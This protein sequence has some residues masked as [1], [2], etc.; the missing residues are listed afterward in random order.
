VEH[1]YASRLADGAFAGPERVDTGL[2]TPGS[3][4]A[5]A[6]SDGGRLVIAFVNNGTVYASVRPAGANAFPAPQPL[7]AGSSPAADMSFNGAAYVVWS[8]G[9]DVRAARL[10]RTATAFAGIAAPLDLDPAQPAGDTAARAPAVAI[11][12]DGTGIATWGEGS[13]VVARRLF[14]ANLS[15]A[16]QD[17]TITDLSGHAGGTADSPRVSMEDDS[18]F[19]WVVF[20]QALDGVNRVVARR[21]VGS[22]F[23]PPQVVDGMGF[24][25]DE[26]LDPPAFAMSGRGVGLAITARTTSNSVW[27]AP[28]QDDTFGMGAARVDNVGNTVDPRPI[29]TFAENND[30]FVA[31]LQSTGPTDPVAIQGRLFDNKQGLLPSGFVSK[32]DLGPVD[33]S[34]GFDAAGDRA[35][36]VA[37]VAIQGTGPDRRLVANLV[38]RAPT[39]SGAFVGHTSQKYRRPGVLSWSAAFDL[40]G[41]LT[42]TVVVDDQPIGQTK[43]TKYTPPT[44]IG[45]GQHRWRVIATDRRGQTL[46]TPSRLLQVDGTPPQLA[47]SSSGAHK[48]G[49]LIKFTFR[50][51]DPDGSGLARIRVEWG[52]G[53]ASLTGAR[54][55]H[56]YRRG[57][58]TLR[59]SATDKA[60]NAAVVTRR[61]TIK[62]R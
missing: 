30:G 41:P 2:D 39:P 11:S 7:G 33:Q 18:S 8:G 1:V 31:W 54:A 47:V 62:K 52:D 57:K 14:G 42:Y 49:K 4:P 34:T 16:P 40:W 24:P 6:A 17:L 35:N 19:A 46:G 27:S 25:P 9:G 23:D 51:G 60:G 59:V 12:A 10:D 22:Q 28:L 29:G 48:A 56:R 55:S 20:R 3:Q 43:D 32:A 36:D 37:V 45:D 26:G 53:T 58:F 44:P 50:A 21:L 15:T 13:H 5:V 38:D 61:L